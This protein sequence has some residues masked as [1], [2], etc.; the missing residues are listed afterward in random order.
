M[1]PAD[2][3][4][5][6]NRFP[7][8]LSRAVPDL[9]ERHG[10]RLGIPGALTERTKAATGDAN[11]SGINMAIDIEVSLV[12]VQTLAHE[13]GHV[14]ESQQI[15]CAVEGDSV[16][17]RKPFACI[18]LVVNRTQRRVFEINSHLV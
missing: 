15:R 2:D 1:E 9:L 11:V 16:I 14:A 8:S 12:A 6:G 13:V 4:K 7:I 3:V 10:V 5:L 18:Y 17:E